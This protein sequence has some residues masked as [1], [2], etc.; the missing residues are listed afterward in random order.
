MGLFNRS[1]KEDPD[2]EY[3]GDANTE[4]LDATEITLAGEPP[5]ADDYKICSGDGRIFMI[6][7][8]EEYFLVW[9]LIDNDERKWIRITPE[10]Q[11]TRHHY[12]LSFYEDNIN[13]AGGVTSDGELLNSVISLNLS[14]LSWSELP[15]LPMKLS[16]ST[17]VVVGSR[18]LFFG[19]QTNKKSTSA[20]FVFNF[21][22]AIWVDPC[23]I[24][25]PSKLPVKFLDAAVLF[26]ADNTSIVISGG[27][28][29]FSGT[30]V[31]TCD[32]GGW[33]IATKT[34]KKTKKVLKEK[35]PTSGCF[36]CDDTL[37]VIYPLSMM[38]VGMSVLNST[39]TS[40]PYSVTGNPSPGC[41]SAQIGD[42]VF[43]VN[44]YSLY[45]ITTPCASTTRDD[46]FDLLDSTTKSE[47]GRE[48][49]PR[50]KDPTPTSSW[51]KGKFFSKTTTNNLLI[52]SDPENDD[53]SPEQQQVCP[54]STSSDFQP[55]PECDTNESP[56]CKKRPSASSP[57]W[58]GKI[59]KS[60]KSNLIGSDS[61]DDQEQEINRGSSWLKGKV[62][63]SKRPVGEGGAAQLEGSA[64]RSTS[65]A[66]EDEVEENDLFSPKDSTSASQ[67]KTR[68]ESWTDKLFSPKHRSK[69]GGNV[70][71]S[72][73][74]EENVLPVGKPRRSAPAIPK[75]GIDLENS[76]SPTD[77]S[78]SQ[79]KSR[80]E[81][82][83]DKLFSPKQRSKS[84]GDV[85]GSDSDDCD[86]DHHLS[87]RKSA[88]SITE[89]SGNMEPS[90]DIIESPTDQLGGPQR[91]ESWTDRLFSPKHKS[92]MEQN[93]L[94]PDDI[95]TERQRNIRPR[96]SLLNAEGE[97][98]SD[99][100]CDLLKS[101]N[102]KSIFSATPKPKQ[103]TCTGRSSKLEDDEGK[104]S[105]GFSL[106]DLL[107]GKGKDQ[108]VICQDPFIEPLSA[109]SPLSPV[110]HPP[111]ITPSN[112]PTV[113]VPVN[114][115]WSAFPSSSNTASPPAAASYGSPTQQSPSWIDFGQAPV[116]HQQPPPIQQQHQQQQQWASF[117]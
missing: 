44:K 60:P 50:L 28:G 111:T 95:L 116:Q 38:T 5:S 23:K 56:H 49:S 97:G 73:S 64:K 15:P 32:C 47:E 94:G 98:D 76:A 79:K 27:T 82:W 20:I 68:Q 55:T 3:V 9:E 77:L 62:F 66:S 105:R 67:K 21:T 85:L 37:H 30:V 110:P 109:A 104:T 33:N 11:P 102:S 75:Q 25:L 14:N 57:S 63:A 29:D 24:S 2:C 59:K 99:D 72:E 54:P 113:G 92:K 35:I 106:G 42:R 52:D 41:S 117:T 46:I 101:T 115:L 80:Q 43:L 61:E 16:N 89:S 71:G 17:D 91:K 26:D 96:K 6:G 93:I 100:D 34:L 103:T 112:T 114:D 13:I 58:F 81:S 4:P 39:T 86:E 48:G 7:S 84:G 40:Y 70:V 87:S 18:W 12:S 107:K 83:T 36:I 1:K 31:L 8:S 10:D 88:P 65:T 78:S 69:S 22:D 90:N 108:S 74:D 53:E 45:E 51:L 19:G